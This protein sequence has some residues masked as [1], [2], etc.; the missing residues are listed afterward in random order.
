MGLL[1]AGLGLQRI[2]WE[3]T[4]MLKKIKMQVKDLHFIFP[5]HRFGKALAQSK[6]G[7]P[8]QWASG[9]VA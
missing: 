5:I 1:K 9:T 6:D 7:P 8:R 3:R 2:G 4:H